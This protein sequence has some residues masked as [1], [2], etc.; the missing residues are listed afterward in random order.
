MAK[1]SK[2]LNKIMTH[3]N[4]TANLQV[5]FVDIEKYSQ[6]RTLTQIGVIDSFTKCLSESLNETSKHYIDYIQKNEINFQNDI[7]KL[8]TGDGAAIIFSFDG[9]HDIHLYFATT[10]LNAI[11]KHNATNECDKFKNH[12]WCNCHSNFNVRIGISE[13]KG[14]I[15]KDLEDKYNVAGS[16]INL[17]SRVMS[18]GDS[19]QIIFTEEAYRQIID[20]VDD[21]FLYDRFQEFKGINIKHNIK[22]NVYHYQD[23]NKPFINSVPP[24][25]LVL[26]QQADEAMQ[27]LYSTMGLS[28]P[29][30]TGSEIDKKTYI[31]MLES[32][33]Q[34]MSLMKKTSVIE[35]V[36]KIEDSIEKQ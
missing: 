3:H 34:A 33:I 6:R 4:R 31:Q 26:K 19:N 1:E 30:L 17:T 22:I 8:P 27:K 9:L 7:I 32:L 10:L 23:I 21:P 20:M 13:G 29:I 24:E 35:Q 18:M 16:V 12:G 2:H 11:F 25:D 14:V 28:S 5:V 15:Y 36:K